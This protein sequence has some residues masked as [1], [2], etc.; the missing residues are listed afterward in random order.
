MKPNKK[1]IFYGFLSKE[2]IGIVLDLQKSQKE[3]SDYYSIIK[4]KGTIILKLNMLGNDFYDS[5]VGIWSGEG[6]D[7]IIGETEYR[8]YLLTGSEDEK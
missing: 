6:F 8:L 5:A 2:F 1:K 4:E 7:K 3:K